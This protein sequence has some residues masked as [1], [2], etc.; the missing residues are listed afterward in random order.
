MLQSRRTFPVLQVLVF[1]FVF[2]AL[3]LAAEAPIRFEAVNPEDAPTRIDKSGELRASDSLRLEFQLTNRSREFLPW[4]ELTAE[5]YRSN[6]DLKG[7]H[8]FTLPTN[9]RSGEQ[10]FFLYRTSE[11]NL[12]PGDRVVLAPTFARLGSGDWSPHPKPVQ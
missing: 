9:L 1:A 4:V 7:F 11:I 2:S 6:G 12:S 10:R 5:I 8:T 3:S